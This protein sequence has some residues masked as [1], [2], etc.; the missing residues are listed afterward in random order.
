MHIR[1]T[2]LIIL[3]CTMHLFLLY[4]QCLQPFPVYNFRAF[5]SPQK[6][7]C[8]SQPFCFPWAATNLLSICVNLPVLDN[9]YIWNHT[10][11][12]LLSLASSHHDFNIHVVMCISTSSFFMTKSPLYEYITFCL[13]SRLFLDI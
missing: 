8:I 4:S 12:G 7:T 11:Q 9:S 5:T 3:K 6:E 13:S 1:V 2:I 10:V